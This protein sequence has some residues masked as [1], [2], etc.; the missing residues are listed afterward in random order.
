MTTSLPTA[1]TAERPTT[2]ARDEIIREAKRLE[3]AT[4]YS[5]KAHHAAARGW[6]GWHMYLGLPLVIISGIATLSQAGKDNF[7]V[8]I[9]AIV[10]SVCVT[11]LSAITTFLNPNE[12]ASAHLTAA[13]AYDKLN[14]EARMFWSIEAWQ[15]TEEALTSRLREL[16][17][18]KDKLNS[19]SP[20][21]PQRA[22]EKGKKQ[23]LAGQARFEVDERSDPPRP[24]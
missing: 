11:I 16:V 9:V 22:Y 24:A 19:D 3:E 23:I 4:L 14:N 13:H 2:H 8:G 1:E 18:R 15:Q 7:W 17:D 5:A 21:I 12:K 6:S 10:A 20:Q